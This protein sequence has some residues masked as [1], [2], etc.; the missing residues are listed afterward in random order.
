MLT[1]ER[2]AQAADDA[3]S[4]PRSP[5][6]VLLGGADR[7]ADILMEKLKERGS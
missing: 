3:L 6:K 1:P 4:L 7:S 2:L 5:H